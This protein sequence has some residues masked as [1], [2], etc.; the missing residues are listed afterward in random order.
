MLSLSFIEN[1]KKGSV[2]ILFFGIVFSLE[3][4]YQTTSVDGLIGF[5]FPIKLLIEVFTGM[6]LSYIGA[7]GFVDEEFTIVINKQCV[8]LNFCIIS[9][10]VLSFGF[11]HWFRKTYE[12]ILWGITSLLCAYVFT[13]IVNAFRII[14][15]LLLEKY[16]SDTLFFTGEILHLAGGIL[17]YFSFLVL[18]FFLVRYLLQKYLNH[19]K[20][21]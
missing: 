14:N 2:Y 8:G 7:I 1:L 19:E 11:S 15:S 4:Y 3:L 12:K 20:A 17:V 6:K 10:C 13:L 21:V 18:Y 9:F 16:L 5:L